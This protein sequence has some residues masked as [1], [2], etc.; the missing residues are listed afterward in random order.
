MCKNVNGGVLINTCDDRYAIL[1]GHE[2]NSE[3]P[4]YLCD[5]RIKPVDDCLIGIKYDGSCYHICYEC[6]ELMS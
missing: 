6:E 2:D 4:C 1:T 5:G 3:V